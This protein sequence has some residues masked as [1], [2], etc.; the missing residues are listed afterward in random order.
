RPAAPAVGLRTEPLPPT[1]AAFAAPTAAP[2]AGRIIPAAPSATPSAPKPAPLPEAKDR[3]G[4]DSLITQVAAVSSSQKV[5]PVIAPTVSSVAN[6]R[7]MSG[8]FDTTGQVQT[9]SGFTGSAI[10]PIGQGF[11]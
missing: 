4:L 8:R 6:V 10:R 5:T 2:A 7:T 11:R 9:A 3:K 1:V